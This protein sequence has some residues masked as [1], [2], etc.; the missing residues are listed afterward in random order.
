MFH[1]KKDI[2]FDL[3]HT[4]WDFEKNS[5][6]AFKTI[7]DEFKLSCSLD[8]FLH[9]YVP[10]NLKYWKLYRDEKISQSELRYHRLKEVFN[11]IQQE[12]SDRLIYQISDAYIEYLPTYNHL[13]EGAIELLDY[14]T[15]NY[16]L[17]IIT[18]GFHSVQQGKL[19]NSGIAK[20]FKTVTN[21]ESTGVK[22]PNP[23]IFNFA[24]HQAQTS[25]QNSLMIGDSWE[26][27]IEGA[28]N[29][30]MDAIFF[31]EFKIEVA[32]IVPQVSELKQ[33]K[34]YL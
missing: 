2:F 15:P 14:L 22:K 25:V 21:S 19:Q 8:Q 33:I 10:T 1:H 7:F 18:N 16:R 12:I 5:A 17:H 23:I 11:G 27:D 9:L 3:D 28:L 34:S 30:G 24:L 31:N 4:L 13:Y 29:L 26:A 6:L 20:Y 32:D